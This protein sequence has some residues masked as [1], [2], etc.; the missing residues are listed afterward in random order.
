MFYNET[1]MSNLATK[2]SV[3][4][5]LDELNTCELCGQDYRDRKD[6]C[7]ECNDDP[8]EDDNGYDQ[9]A[10]EKNEII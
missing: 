8:N 3:A 5:L 9:V 10:Q 1:V 6:Y 2:D 4:K 7:P